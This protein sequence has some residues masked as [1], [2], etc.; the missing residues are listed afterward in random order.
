MFLFSH[1][2]FLRIFSS[3]RECFLKQIKF[4]FLLTYSWSESSCLQQ[5]L[6]TKKFHKEQLKKFGRLQESFLQNGCA[7][8]SCFL[9]AAR[10][11]TMTVREGRV[12]SYDKLVG[13]E[14]Q[15]KH[16]GG[17]DFLMISER[18]HNRWMTKCIILPTTDVNRVIS[19]LHVQRRKWT[20]WFPLNMWS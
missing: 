10:T 1:S 8:C 15:A 5:W 12:F 6:K 14:R 11:S 16:C 20:E 18:S 7:F 4:W 2:F 3:Q 19:L 13:G 9:G 17:R